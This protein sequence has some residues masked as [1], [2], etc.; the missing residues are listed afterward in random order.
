MKV[1]DL[2]IKFISMDS[3][4]A[5]KDYVI[6]KIGKLDNFLE[7]ATK[8]E[9]VLKERVQRRGVDKDFRIDI[10]ISMPNSL[11]IVQEA[12]EDLY[13]IIDKAVD[14][15]ARRLKR[16]QD[17]LSQW[18]GEEPWKVVHAAEALA[19]FEPEED[20]DEYADYVPK[21]AVYKK[22]KDLKPRD[23]AEAI[24]EM[25]LKGFNQFLFKNKKGQ[26]SMIYKRDDGSYGL[27]EPSEEI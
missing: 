24:E 7:R 8:G 15:L 10:N 18:E 6:Q 1:E 22:I 20:F 16:Y 3:T 17:K 9:V 23:Y 13:A 27:V 4:E 26:F 19:E 5:I 2:Q 14:V 21:I 11:I 12:G 25:E